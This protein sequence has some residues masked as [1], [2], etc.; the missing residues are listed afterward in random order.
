MTVLQEA[1][2][3][4]KRFKAERLNLSQVAE[5]LGV[6]RKTAERKIAHLPFLDMD[7]TRRYRV[8]DIAEFIFL[9]TKRGNET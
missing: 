5:W 1:A 7:G 3:M 9:H 6:D 2:A 8:T 4:R